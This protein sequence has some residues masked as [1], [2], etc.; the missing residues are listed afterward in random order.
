MEAGLADVQ[1]LV[2][3]KTPI[4]DVRM[5]MVLVGSHPDDGQMSLVVM[6]NK[7]WSQAVPGPV[8]ELVYVARARGSKP[9]AHPI[10]QVWDY[11]QV[12]IDYIPL[13]RRAAKVHCVVN[14]HNATSASLAAIRPS[15]VGLEYDPTVVRM[16]CADHR[17]HFKSTLRAVLT[18][19]GL[20]PAGRAGR[21]LRA[22]IRRP[23]R[24]L[25]RL[26]VLPP[27]THP[28]RTAARLL[29]HHHIRPML[30]VREVIVRLGHRR[31]L[32]EHGVL[33]R[34]ARRIHSLDR[35]L[36]LLRRKRPRSGLWVRVQQRDLLVQQLVPHAGEHLPQA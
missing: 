34:P 24:L 17:E 19:E 13:V 35:S 3:L 16:Y 21:H 28:A 15:T 5:D 6:E 33:Q 25:G 26:A 10:K 11:R 8:P 36:Q 2:E 4:S 1:V 22:A 20:R 23:H 30:L 29:R 18:P 7:Q 32:L 31:V 9:Y 27:I 12:L 14:M